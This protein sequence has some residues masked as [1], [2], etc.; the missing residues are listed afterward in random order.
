MIYLVIIIIITAISVLINMYF[1]HKRRK[2]I[3]TLW[4]HNKKLDHRENYHETFKFFYE[5]IKESNDDAGI[6][7]ITWNDLNMT[8][9]FNNINYAFTSI[10]EEMLYFRL[11]AAHKQHV[12]DEKMIEKISSDSP[13]RVKLSLILAALGKAPYTNSS[14]HMFENPDVKI[15]KLFLVLSILPLVGL[16]LIGVSLHAGLSLFFTSAL[17]NSFLFY[18]NRSKNEA[19]FES[20]SYCIHII[21]TSRKIAKLNKD[22]DFLK[23]TNNLRKAP[24]ISVLLLKDDTTGTNIILHILTVLKAIFLLEYLVFHYIIHLLHHNKDLY[25]LAWKKTAELDFFYSIAIWRKTLPYY[26]VPT[27]NGEGSFVIHEAYHPL[28]QNPVGNDFTFHKNC[29]L[30]GSNAS[31]KSTFMKTIALNIVFSQALNTSTSKQIN[32][33]RGP[34]YSTMAMAD[35]IEKG[36][37]YFLSEII[38]LKR[39]FDTVNTDKQSFFYLFIDEIFKGTNTVERIAAAESVLN[40]LNDCKQTR[41]MAATHDIELTEMLASKYTNYHF[42]EYISNDEIYFDYLIKDGASNTRNAIELLRITNFPKK[43][44]D[45]ALKKIAEQSK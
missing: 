19:E 38:A 18:M 8:K 6:D 15:N 1:S 28:L 25:E 5:N 16:G 39:I 24:F 9:I 17:V 14:K 26:C 4:D 2:Q 43:V 42:R 32:L 45:D 37:S 30:T 22:T 29:L 11:K 44:Y 12:M 41:V 13:F 35:D 27:F 31:G 7:D 21:L 40:Y 20:L 33:T 10:G 34:V 36:Q 3:L 23:K